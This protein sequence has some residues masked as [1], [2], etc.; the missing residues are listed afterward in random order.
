MIDGE[1]TPEGCV[2]CN[3]DEVRPLLERHGIKVEEVP[4]PRHAWTDVVCCTKCGRAWLLLP[5]KSSSKTPVA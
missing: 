3:P 2:G 4:R 1:E 5:R